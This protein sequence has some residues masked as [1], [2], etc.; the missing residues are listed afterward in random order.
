MTDTNFWLSDFKVL[1]N[2]LDFFPNKNMSRNALLNS[3]TRYA[4]IILVIFIF[5]RSNYYWCYLPIGIIGSC[6]ILYLLDV[7]K[8]KDD[9]IQQRKDNYICRE[10][11][12]NNPYMN[13]LAT[14]DTVDLPACDINKKKY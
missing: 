14:Q 9:K 4:L 1:Y 10:P 7:Q 8:Q 12:I 13:I 2:N 5:I 11:N 3:L 6:I